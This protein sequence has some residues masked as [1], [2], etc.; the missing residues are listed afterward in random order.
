LAFSKLPTEL[1]GRISSSHRRC[2]AF[3]N[4]NAVPHAPVRAMR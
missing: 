3:E 2:A 4:A 1:T